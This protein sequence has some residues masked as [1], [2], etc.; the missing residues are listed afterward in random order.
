[1]PSA[2][3]ILAALGAL[4]AA[5]IPLAILWHLLVAAGLWLWWRGWRPD[6]RQAL[7]A[8]VLPIASAS[9]AAWLASNP[10]NGAV[11][12]ILAVALG[13]QAL[14]V[15]PAPVRVSSPGWR[16][17]SLGLIGFAW[18]YPHFL[19]GHSPLVYLYAAPMGVLPCPSLALALGVSLAVEIDGT[20]AHAWW[21]VAGA[22]FYAAFGVLFL[23]VRLD[24]PLLAGGLLLLG[25]TV[26][27]GRPHAP[28]TL[29]TVAGPPSSSSATTSG[30]RAQ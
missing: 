21:L 4:A 12:A 28:P 29:A 24:L 2:E 1:M 3:Q 7:V 14:R 11:L 19:P 30:A 13:R 6:Q 10:V 23:G 15:A 25:R 16:A 20:R 9:L 18:V 8:M 5:G 27:T 17:A 26:A 22:L